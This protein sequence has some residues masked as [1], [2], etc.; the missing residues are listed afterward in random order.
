MNNM[1]LIL[2]AIAVMLS[3]QIQAQKLEKIW[4]TPATLKTPE[5]V[6]FNE[7]YGVAF[8]ACMGEVRDTKNGDGYL[9]QISLK[10][11]ILNAEWL[12][13]L[14]DPKG[15][16]IREG[17]LYV[18]DMDELVIIDIESA[19]IDKRFLIPEAKFLNDVTVC[20]NG[21]VFV[22]D[23]RDQ[24]IYAYSND[25]FKSWLQDPKLDN[26][27]GLWAEG[28]KLYA[29]NSSVWEIDIKTKEMK[30]L[31]D[32]TGGIDGLET[33]WN[34]NFIFSNWGGKIY[35]SDNGNV[36]KLLDVSE[37][38]RNTADIDYVPM[39]QMVLVPTF[40][41]NSVDA[42]RLVYDKLN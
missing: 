31:F 7:T 18:A 5:S 33:I 30:A 41:Q 37:E 25:E 22:S 40:F 11:E 26:V 20:Q 9:A 2:L 14:N 10:G 15:M 4:S 38:K 29:G 42:Y 32:G 6:L 21:M 1:K 36:I 16:A 34:G 23:M 39:N 19:S 8:V 28:G 12:T 13:G 35:V 3:M 27:N 17:K 24:R